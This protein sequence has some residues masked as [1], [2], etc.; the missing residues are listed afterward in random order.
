M[1]RLYRLEH[2]FQSGM[3]FAGLRRRNVQILEIRA[4]IQSGWKYSPGSCNDPLGFLYQRADRGPRIAVQILSGL[5]QEAACPKT[6]T[7]C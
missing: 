5:P 6:K 3:C 4:G 2:T 1:R 7:R